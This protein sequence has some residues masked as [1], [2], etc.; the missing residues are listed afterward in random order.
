MEGIVKFNCVWNKETIDLL[1]AEEL[2][3]LNYWRDLLRK[4]SLIG[5]NEKGLGF[6]NISIRLPDGEKFVITGSQTGHLKELKQEDLALVT[7]FSLKNNYVMCLGFT[8]ASSEALSHA[9]I[10]SSSREHRAVIHFHSR[11]IWE[12][13]F[14]LYSSSDPRAAYGTPELAESIKDI[15]TNHSPKDPSVI[16]LGGHPEGVITFGNSLK[17]AAEEALKLAETI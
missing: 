17:R 4:K 8:K 2:R 14:Y 1:T 7:D 15:L 12:K 11:R 13:S 16:L 9:A 10:Y 3:E 5:A 6:G